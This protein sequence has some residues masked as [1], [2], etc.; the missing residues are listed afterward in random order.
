M[1]IRENMVFHD[2][3]PVTAEDIKFTFDYCK[4]WKVPYWLSQLEVIESVNVMDKYSLQFRLKEPFGP[5]FSG[6]FST[7]FILPKHIW[8]NVVEKENLKDPLE[9][10]NPKP[11]GSGPFKFDYWERGAELKLT[12]F[13]RHFHPPNCK[14]RIRIKYGSWDAVAGAIRSGACHRNQLAIAS[15]STFEPLMNAPNVDA[16]YYKNHGVFNMAYNC[17]R[18]PFNDPVFRRSLAHVLPRKLF[19]DAILRGHVEIGGSVISS[20]NEFWHNPEVKPF[21]EDV[22][23]ARQMLKEAGYGWDEKGRLHYPPK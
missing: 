20:F 23:K 18:A 7:I 12:R 22:G 8:E 15:I 13:D 16:R 6:L 19:R 1:T 3:V 17:S 21:P 10:A 9:W 11:I 5:I 14:G 2:G 4:K